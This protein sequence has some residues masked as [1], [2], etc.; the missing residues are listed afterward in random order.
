LIV[1]TCHAL[2]G[3]HIFHTITCQ[4]LSWI[5]QCLMDEWAIIM[6]A[7][8]KSSL[9]DKPIQMHDGAG[10]GQAVI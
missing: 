9:N 1:T 5:M 7:Q 6:R 8:M 2:Q 10:Q 4:G 3:N